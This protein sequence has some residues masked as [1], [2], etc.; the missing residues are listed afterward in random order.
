M[1]EKSNVKQKKE[2]NSKTKIMVISLIIL[3][4][5]VVIAVAGYFLYRFKQEL[6]LMNEASTIGQMDVLE[7]TIDMDIKTSGKYAKVEQTMKQYMKEASEKMKQL[8]S[9]YLDESIPQVIG[10][11]NIKQD[12]PEFTATLTKLEETKKQV[13][14]LLEQITPLL[15]E[16]TVM[17]R[18]KQVPELNQYYTNLYYKMIF[19]DGKT[20]E[21]FK[22]AKDQL[23]KANAKYIELIDLMEELLT[24]LKDHKANWEIQKNQIMFDKQSVLDTYQEIVARI[25]S[26]EE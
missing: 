1:E 15:E 18:I 19:G 2:K 3:L 10:I 9:I 25:T 11:D 24:F 20:V 5:I 4:I 13:N 17:G 23:T 8:N 7:Q 21:E 22:I 16:E 14:E 6:T 12:G 26:L